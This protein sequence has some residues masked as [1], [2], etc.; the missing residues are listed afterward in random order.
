MIYFDLESTIEYLCVLRLTHNF[1]KLKEAQ[2]Q[3]IWVKEKSKSFRKISPNLSH[4]QQI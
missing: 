3:R 4:L 1:K 2:K